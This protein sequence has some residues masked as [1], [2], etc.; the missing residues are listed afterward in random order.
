VK[1]RVGDLHP[2]MLYRLL[3]EGQQP[4]DRLREPHRRC[5]GLA[6]VLF[7]DS[8]DALEVARRCGTVG[9]GEAHPTPHLSQAG[10]VSL[11]LAGGEQLRQAATIHPTT[12]GH[13]WPRSKTGQPHLQ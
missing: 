7:T 3:T 11:P 6:G 8:V 9:D 10:L 2:P 12:V 13:P 5:P 1:G 4:V